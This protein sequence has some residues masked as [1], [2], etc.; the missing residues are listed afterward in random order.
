MSISDGIKQ[1]MKIN[2]W[3]TVYFNFHYFPFKT[4]MRMPVFIYKRTLLYKMG[5]KI[6]I[7]APVRTGMM[8]FGPHGLG[9]QDLLYSR[10]MWQLDGTLVIKGRIDIG[11]GSKISVGKNGVLTLGKDFMI[12]GNSE[13]ICQ[14][15]ITFGSECL[16]SWNVLVMDTDFHKI[17]DANNVLI[18]SPRPIHIGNHVWIGCKNMILKGVSV[19][20]NVIV[21]ANS[22]VT[23]NVSE[24]NCIIGGQGKYIEV[25]K[26]NVRWEK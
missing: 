11:R 14:K 24:T 7:E 6:S 10:T 20:D 2:L 19:A 22:T 9:T 17:Y 5:G 8:R 15:E 4:A 16:L 25:L 18:N 23:R 21:S 12:T 1:L 13:I 3:K 26:R